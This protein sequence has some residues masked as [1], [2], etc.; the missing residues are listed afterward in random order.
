MGIALGD[1]AALKGQARDIIHQ[2]ITNIFAPLFFVSIGLYVNLVDFFD[3]QLVVLV[4]VLATVGKLFGAV[5]GAYM[6]GLSLRPAFV[7]GFGMNAR[8]AMEIVLSTLAYKSGIIGQHLFV[9]LII[10]ALLTSIAAGPLMRYFLRDPAT[11]EL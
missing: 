8:G 10:M 3:L 11:K 5:L 7:V 2:F 4:L 1:C 9:A 6:G